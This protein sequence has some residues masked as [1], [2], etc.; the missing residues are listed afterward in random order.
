MLV[1][2]EDAPESLASSYVEVGGL[3]RISNRRR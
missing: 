3:L 1:F 2:V